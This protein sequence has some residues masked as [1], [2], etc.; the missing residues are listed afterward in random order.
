VVETDHRRADLRLSL[1]RT[2][3]LDSLGG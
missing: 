1:T 3:R 2:L